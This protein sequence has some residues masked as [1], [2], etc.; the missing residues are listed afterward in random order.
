MIARTR[1]SFGSH[2]VVASLATLMSVGIG[3][4]QDEALFEY[5]EPNS[6]DTCKADCGAASGCYG[7]QCVGTKITKS[8]RPG[9][10]SYCSRLIVCPGVC[11]PTP[12]VPCV[13]PTSGPRC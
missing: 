2:L 13:C 6:R 12:G 11:G 10:A 1:A 3:V 4:A 7:Y 5:C 8:C 9:L